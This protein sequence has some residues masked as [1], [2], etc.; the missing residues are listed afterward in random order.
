MEKKIKCI[1]VKECLNWSGEI[2]KLKRVNPKTGKKENM[3]Q[4]PACCQW[5]FESE[6][7]EHYRNC[8]DAKRGLGLMWI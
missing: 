8:E 4:C 6:Y 3:I 2:M 7:D 1:V 5:V